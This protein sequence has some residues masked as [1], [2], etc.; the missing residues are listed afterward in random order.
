M[1]ELCTDPNPNFFFGFGQFLRIHSHSDP[2]HRFRDVF[3][4][5]L[6][7]ILIFSGLS[8]HIAVFGVSLLYSFFSLMYFES[9][10]FFNLLCSILSWS[11]WHCFVSVDFAKL[12]V[13]T[14]LWSV[15]VILPLMCQSTRVDTKVYFFISRNKKLTFILRWK[16]VC[17][18]LQIIIFYIVTKV[19]FC[20]EISYQPYSLP[21]PCVV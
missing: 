14:L 1:V 6:F 7:F 4:W 2:Q 19:I 16:N 9:R 20:C 8:V 17:Q 21:Y 5:Y 11:T 18:T 13:S 10:L 3:F 15:S 12:C